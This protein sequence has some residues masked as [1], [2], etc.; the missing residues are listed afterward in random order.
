[1]KCQYCGSMMN[2]DDIYCSNC[3]NNLTIGNN[4]NNHN[5]YQYPNPNINQNNLGQGG[6]NYPPMQPKKTST[7]TILL[8]IFGFFWFIV[9]GFIVLCV[10]IGILAYDNTKNTTLGH[11][12]PI[13]IEDFEFKKTIDDII[14]T[15]HCSDSF[16]S[17][18]YISTARFENDM[19]FAWSK[20][21]DE[22]NNH[23]YGEFKFEDL[24][25]KDSNEVYNYY[26]IKLNGEEYVKDS[27]IQNE[28]F[29]ANL[30]IGIDIND[31]S[32]AIMIEANTPDIFYCKIEQ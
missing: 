27:I 22:K 23:I 29:K 3:G 10:I 25:K 5:Q 12:E 6:Y 4:F 18:E 9:I 20:F 1:M 2:N 11:P 14:G 13:D 28:E 15:W 17:T 7:A 21:D 19:T 16:A 24:H 26:L 32:K 8:S 31:K 30:E